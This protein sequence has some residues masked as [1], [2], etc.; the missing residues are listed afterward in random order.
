MILPRT[1]ILAI[2]TK[3]SPIASDSGDATPFSTENWIKMSRTGSMSSSTTARAPHT[4]AWTCLY[5][6]RM[7][8][9]RPLTFFI[10][11]QPYYLYVATLP[12]V[13][14]R[15]D[16]LTT[17]ECPWF[18]QARHRDPRHS[19]TGQDSSATAI[20]SLSTK[21]EAFGLIWWSRRHTLGWIQRSDAFQWPPDWCWWIQ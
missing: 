8:K 21:Y 11:L 15:S 6:Y 16:W 7:K 9:I 12:P 3:V 2:V 14:P 10:L 20:N 1:G 4:F 17:V 19:K 18:W 13:Y 5:I